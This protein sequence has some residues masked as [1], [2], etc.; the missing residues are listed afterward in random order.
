MDIEDLQNIVIKLSDR[1]TLSIAVDDIRSFK[2]AIG[3]NLSNSIGKTD[4]RLAN[5]Y[6][7][8]GIAVT[9]NRLIERGKFVVFKEVGYSLHCPTGIEIVYVGSYE[10]DE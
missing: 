10:K 2:N 7:F 1:H 6:M 9:E 4:A 5:I 3:S 8:N